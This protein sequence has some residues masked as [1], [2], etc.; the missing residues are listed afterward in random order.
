MTTHQFFP[1]YCSGTEQLTLS[2]AREL[3]RRGHEVAVYTGYP[4]TTH[5]SE[6]ERFDSYQFNGIPVHRFHHTYQLMDG[7]R[8]K[9]ALSFDNKLA[10][11]RFR[12]IMEEFRPDIVHFFHLNRLGSGLI[13]AA[14]DMRSPAFY[15]P[16]DF[17]AICH[18]AQLHL[19]SGAFCPGPTLH[20]GN[21]AKHLAES[22]AYSPFRFVAKVTPIIAFEQVTRMASRV[23]MLGFSGLSEFGAIE[24]RLRINRDRMNRL[25]GIVSPNAFMTETLMRYG[26]RKELLHEL[27]YGI[28]DPF[29]DA[30]PA[31]QESSQRLRIGF[32]GTLAQHK[33]C[34]VLID[35][36]KLA[37]QQ[38]QA[39]LKIYGRE[40]DFPVYCDRLRLL[41]GGRTDIEFCGTFQNSEIGN[42]FN[43]LDVLVVPSVWFEN[44]P[45]V[46]YSAMA[47]K[48]PV[49]A[50]DIPGITACIRHDST[51]LVFK[52]G[53]HKSLAAQ[54]IRFL[55]DGELRL[56]LINNSR[57]PS[58]VSDYV[59]GL[60]GLWGF[61][62]APH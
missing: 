1:D 15:T 33:G 13:D 55:N 45:L 34:H 11:D 29:E 46:I 51:G 24:R 19:P 27:A 9:I 3:L 21:C 36:F 61:G 58:S 49:I 8:S 18:T 40:G 26:I 23:E 25:S 56:R 30:S 42:I 38:D 44:T 20:A 37:F 28:D 57:K 31:C 14:V 47:A 62:A 48:C 35:A 41:V 53:D 7:Q 16:T 59:D 32:I 10:K 52:S 17:W 22:H 39:V 6:G 50:S 43:C 2:V 12:V 4:S 5:L 60:I 54:L